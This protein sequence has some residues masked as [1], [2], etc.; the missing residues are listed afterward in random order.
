MPSDLTRGGQFAII[1]AKILYDAALPATAK[2]LYGELY[3][4][5][6]A[7]GYCYPSNAELAE[8]VGCSDKT[9]TRLIA[10]LRD[11]GHIRVKMIRR[12]GQSGDI[13]QRR[14]F[15]GLELAREDP[16]E[17]G[18][19][20]PKEPARGIPKN[21]ETYPQN[22]PDGIPKNEEDTIKK[23]Y[24]SNTPIVPK[25]KSTLKVALAVSQRLLE[26]AGEDQELLE[27]LCGLLE[28]RQVANH[29]P[30]KTVLAINGILRDLDK[31]SGGNRAMKLQLLSKATLSNWLTVYPLR[32]D[33]LPVAAAGGRV[34]EGEG[35]RYI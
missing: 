5:S 28:N 9:V 34:T 18:D 14:I 21:K 35:V 17:G 7:N 1:H 8:I 10:S 15:C 2:L 3:R 12:F 6:A 33:E 30:V 11:A 27:A 26:Y 4:L 24:L 20:A 16:Q 29:K 13:V 19:D 31:L 22:C 23:E 32:Q 25:K